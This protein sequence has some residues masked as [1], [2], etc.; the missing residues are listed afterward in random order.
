MLDPSCLSP[1]PLAELF[2]PA[3][4]L[5]DQVSTSTEWDIG[6]K[7]DIM[8]RRAE[9]ISIQSFW[10][11]GRGGCPCFI[12]GC[13]GLLKGHCSWATFHHTQVQAAVV[14]LPIV[15]HRIAVA[16]IY[17]TRGP[18]LSIGSQARTAVINADART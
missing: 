15:R 12:A 2:R 16:P 1:R 11:S 18:T 10:V 17:I 4:V 14:H 6:Q 5:I 13:S 8:T 3:G 7:K 9:V